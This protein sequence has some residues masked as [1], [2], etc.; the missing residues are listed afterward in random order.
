[1]T[2]I[3]NIPVI[4]SH[5][6]LWDISR[7]K[8]AWLDEVPPI[9][10][11]FL[12]TD[13]QKATQNTDIKK[14]VFVQCECEPAQCVDEI[15][16]V[17]EQAAIDKRIQG[18]V[19]YAPMEKGKSITDLLN[20][21]KQNKLVKGVRRMYD[22]TPSLCHSSDFIAALNLLPQYGYNFDVSIKPGSMPATLQMIKNCPDTFFI[23]AHLG[24]PDI[25]NNGLLAFQKNVDELAAL[26]NVVAKISG[27]ITEADLQN[28]S[29]ETLKPYIEHALI[30]FGPDRLTFGGDWPVVLLA[31]N[32]EQWLNTITEI[33]QHLSKAELKKIF[34]SNAEIF[35][36][37]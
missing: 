21:Y 7:L 37:L 23:I 4:D 11:T 30:T 10:K 35:Y 26:P 34:Y 33:L 17:M 27:L 5:L 3:M 36:K 13:Y 24:K 8:Y 14:M 25:I 12:I 2:E 32:F 18:I 29:A 15:N 19:A 9:N 6:H 31:G 16:F 28:W 22:G 1:M 20:V